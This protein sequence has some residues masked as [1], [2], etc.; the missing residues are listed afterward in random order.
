MFSNISLLKAASAMAL[1]A[2][3]LS[4]VGCASHGTVPATLSQERS[5]LHEI[6]PSLG[7]TFSA[8]YRGRDAKKR[9]KRGLCFGWTL[10]GRG[11]A[12]FLGQSQVLVI[13][14]ENQGY[15]AGI[16]MKIFPISSPANRI[17][18]GAAKGTSGPCDYKRYRSP[19]D[20][21]VDFGKGRFHRARGSGTAVFSCGSHTFSVVLNGTL[22]Y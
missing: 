16:S 2:L 7:G 21:S 18:L 5:A 14:C 22:H 19:L 17:E 20:W 12:A 11:E 6:S 4:I 3:L 13:Y 1:A 8:T 15:G 10:D 9:L